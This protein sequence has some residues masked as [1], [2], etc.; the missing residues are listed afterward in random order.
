MT[1]GIAIAIENESAIVIS[2]VCVSVSASPLSGVSDGVV[3]N[4]AP[5]PD[6]D[7][8]IEIETDDVNE[9]GNESDHDQ[10]PFDL[11]KFDLEP[12][13][14]LCLGSHDPCPIPYHVLCLGRNHAH[15]RVL[16]RVLGR[17]PDLV[18]P[19]P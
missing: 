10:S 9:S 4:P 6:L 14:C 1:S 8:V 16:Y 5:A 11:H 18:C 19:S 15:A 3:P 13:L 2:N 12:C 17:D 7:P